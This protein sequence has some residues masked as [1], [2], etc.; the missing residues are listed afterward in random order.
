MLDD[1]SK[2]P[3]GSK[4]NHD[5][6]ER[7]EE[8]QERIRQLESGS[9]R[10]ENNELKTDD[11]F[12]TEEQTDEERACVVCTENLANIAFSPCGHAVTCDVC[13]R[14]VQKCPMCRSDIKTRLQLY[15]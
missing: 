6:H 1:V 9:H 13:S 8:L 10:T 2:L 15:Y 5:L 11:P 12:S 3:D 4:A 14:K 7:N